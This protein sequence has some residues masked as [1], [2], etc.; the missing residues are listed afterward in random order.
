M[1]CMPLAGVG[2]TTHVDKSNRLPGWDTGSWA[3][4]GDDGNAF[5]GSNGVKYG[6]KFGTGIVFDLVWDASSS[7]F[8]NGFGFR[9]GKA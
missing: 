3:Y 2:F 5:Q 9:V 1:L 8:R 4:H 7:K 6:P